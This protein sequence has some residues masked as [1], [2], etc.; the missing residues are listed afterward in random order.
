M[1]IPYQL[2]NNAVAILFKQYFSSIW[3][4]EQTWLYWFSTNVFDQANITYIDQWCTDDMCTLKLKTAGVIHRS[5]RRVWRFF[6]KSQRNMRNRTL[7][8]SI[9][10]R[11]LLICGLIEDVDQTWPCKKVNWPPSSQR[12]INILKNYDTDTTDIIIGFVSATYAI[13]HHL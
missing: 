3:E 2:G 10:T 12:G 9:I 8:V 1:T 5:K 4:R 6:L 11:I 7:I 13:L